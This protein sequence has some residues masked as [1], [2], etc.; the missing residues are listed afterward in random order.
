[1]GPRGYDIHFPGGR[2]GN[3]TFTCLIEKR[4]QI[5]KN[6]SLFFLPGKS[7]KCLT[8]KSSRLCVSLWPWKISSSFCNILWR[9]HFPLVWHPLS[10]W[11]GWLETKAILAM[12]VWSWG[13]HNE[14]SSRWVLERVWQRALWPGRSIGGGVKRCRKR[15]QVPHF[16]ESQYHQPLRGRQTEQAPNYQIG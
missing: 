5:K 6:L 8:Q 1:M 11:N 3:E 9:P 4:E 15:G 14:F 2:A 13:S 16:S 10:F 12:T 7:P